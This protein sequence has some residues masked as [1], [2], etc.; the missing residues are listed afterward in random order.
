MNSR[1]EAATSI[2]RAR[3]PLHGLLRATLLALALFSPYVVGVWARFGRRLSAGAL[4][5]TLVLLGVLWVL[6][7]SRSV[8]S[9][10]VVVAIVFCFLS[11]TLLDIMARPLIGGARSPGFAVAWPPMP[12]VRRYLPNTRFRGTIY[13]ELAQTP[14]LKR[15]REYH[16]MSFVT[17]RFGF[18]N[19]APVNEPLDVIALGDSYTAAHNATQ[20]AMWSTILSKQYGL[21]VYNLAVADDGPWQE[22]TNLMLEI[23][24]LRIKPRGT[25]VLWNLFTANDLSVACYPIFRRDQ[26]PWRHGLGRLASEFSAF[27]SQSPLGRVLARTMKRTGLASQDTG[28]VLKNFVD[29]SGIIF[30]AGFARVA[31]RRLDDVRRDPNY[32]CLRQTISAM[33]RFA[34]SR[35]LTVAIM[36]S[37]PSEEVYSWVL[38]GASP[39][40]TTADPSGFVLAVQ[41][42]ARE[43][44]IPL[45]DLKPSLVEASKRVY[46]ES[47][48][49]LWARDDSHWNTDGNVEVAKVAYKFY[50]SVESH[51]ADGVH[52]SR[53][54]VSTRR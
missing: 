21:R 20:E 3:A 47:G 28:L 33:K 34:D 41:E 44:H 18:R 43:N 19:A 5:A 8:R 17:D 25:V 35:N 29:G 10:K 24:R 49:L 45:L 42:M 53:D 48:H 7:G 2:R 39:W 50:T 36:V 9:H 32:N 27:R 40:S 11:V 38:H 31:D 37:P 26:L 4:G 13:G 16:E 14:G 30:Y 51:V 6:S 23:D 1:Y 12:L 46:Q 22:F 52:F 15:Y 54:R